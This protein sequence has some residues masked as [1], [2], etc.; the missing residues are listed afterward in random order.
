[1]IPAAKFVNMRQVPKAQ[2]YDLMPERF[3]DILMTRGQSLPD[4][5]DDEDE[6]EVDER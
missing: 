4:D 1:M 2:V 6:E 5:E 3:K